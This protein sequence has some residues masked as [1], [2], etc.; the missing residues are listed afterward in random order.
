MIPTTATTTPTATTITARR[1]RLVA[2]AAAL[3]AAPHGRSRS[4]SLLAATHG[5]DPALR[6]RRRSL[7]GVLAS[8]SRMR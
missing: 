5:A 8:R 6:R 7:R 1:T 4:A 2:G 3:V